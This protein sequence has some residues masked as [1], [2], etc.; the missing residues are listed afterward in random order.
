MAIINAW[1]PRCHATKGVYKQWTSTVWTGILD[2]QAFPSQN[3]LIFFNI[4]SP[5][6]NNI[7]FKNTT[8][9]V[10]TSATCLRPSEY[11]CSVVKFYM[12]LWSR[13][14]L[15]LNVSWYA[16]QI[17]VEPFEASWYAENLKINVTQPIF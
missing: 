5:C 8:V 13:S 3:S 11:I 10:V 4:N 15:R 16:V 17:N 6:N 2:S 1:L 14:H 12:I 7:P 9:T